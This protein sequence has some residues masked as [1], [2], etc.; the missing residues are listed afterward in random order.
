[1]PYKYF[2]GKY[3]HSDND[4]IP[5]ARIKWQK[6]MKKMRVEKFPTGKNGVLNEPGET[7]AI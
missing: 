7:I 3:S 6:A 4:M 2:I 1:M 5:F